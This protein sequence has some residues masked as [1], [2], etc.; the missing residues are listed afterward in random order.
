MRALILTISSIAKALGE[1]SGNVSMMIEPASQILDTRFKIFEGCWKMFPG[2]AESVDGV[3]SAEDLFKLSEIKSPKR[4]ITVYGRPGGIAP[5]RNRASLFLSAF[6]RRCGRG[7]SRL[8]FSL[9]IRFL[10]FF[11]H[12]DCSYC[13][14]KNLSRM[15][16]VTVI[17]RLRVRV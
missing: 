2:A 14:A 3:K 5:I 17:F 15:K 4:R 8:S 11:S 9:S 1:V 16:R 12:Y 6:G 7:R 13:G 10:R